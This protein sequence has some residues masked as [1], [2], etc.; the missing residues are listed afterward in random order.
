MFNLKKTILSMLLVL[1]MGALASAQQLADS[2]VVY[3]RQ[4][5]AA[6]DRGYRQN[7][8]RCEGFLKT[9]K[10]MPGL[11]TVVKVE[12]YGVTSPEGSVGLNEKL[13]RKRAE[14]IT[15]YLHRHIEFDDD[16][17][18]I[19][20]VVEDWAGLEKF[21][22]NDPQTPDREAV[23]QI[24]RSDRNELR[25]KDLKELNGGAAWRYLY[26]KYFSDLRFC[27]VIV[28]TEL[29]IEFADIIIEEDEIVPDEIFI[30]TNDTLPHLAQIPM[31]SQR[32]LTL[33]TNVLGW[34]LLGE[35]IAV[36][37]DII[38]HLSVAVPFY[39]SGGLDYFKETLKFRGIVL[40]PELRYYPWLNDY[41]CN[42]GFYVGAHFGLG[43]YNFALNG[44]YRVQDHKGNTPSF[45]GGL[46][47]GYTL[48]FKKNPRWG[49]EFA[50]GGGVYKS[51]YDLFYNEGNGPIHQ[52][53]IEKVWFGV[54]NAAISFT[55]KF[56]VKKGGKK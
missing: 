32:K 16:V 2:L 45:G 56:D 50:V 37:F 3:F 14:V 34:A 21:V 39:Y 47:L 27:R 53:A 4:G 11:L 51:K 28:S 30:N 25:E 18:F 9:I 40:Q 55:Y 13:S 52:E 22:M 1:S 49:M 12:Y 48:Q 54:D 24:I 23:L 19:Y 29:G 20:S 43:W 6:F 7:G 42:G 10:E 35:N 5:S 33:K 38:P 41:G 46:G 8:E 31:V 26:R 17:V 15:D 36:E 44:D